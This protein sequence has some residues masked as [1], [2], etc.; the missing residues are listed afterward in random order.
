MTVRPRQAQPSASSF[1]SR[2]LIV[3]L[4][5]VSTS[6]LAQAQVC[7]NSREECLEAHGLPGCS[8]EQCCLAVCGLDSFCCEEWDANCA[9]L[10]DLTC[11]G[12]CGAQASGSCFAANGSGG[13][14]D[15]ACCGIVCGL[16][17]YCCDQ[18]WDGNCSLFAG[19]VCSVPGG[20]CGDPGTGDCAESNGT[21]SCEDAECCESVC[22]IDATC[23]D[24]VWDQLCVALADQACGGF[25]VVD[26][27]GTESMEAEA[28]DG[29]S[30]DP[31]DGGVAEEI[32][33][34]RVTVGTFRS[35][36]DVDVFRLDLTGRDV[37]ED[38]LVRMRLLF[39]ASAATLRF[40]GD[41]CRSTVEFEVSSTACIPVA[42]N[43]CLAADV[44]WVEIFPT[45]VI[46][47]CEDPAW[48]LDLETADTCGQIC[49]RPEDCLEPHA[50]PG[51]SDA[52]CCELVCEQDPECCEWAWDSTCAVQA[53]ALCG[54]P[55]PANDA[56]G[57]AIDIGP[58]IHPFRQ[59]LSSAEGLD[60]ECL[61]DPG[62]RGGD[63]W[64]RYQSTCDGLLKVG[65]C[66]LADFDTVVDVFAG[67]CKS[68]VPVVCLDDDIFC[69]FDT[70]SIFFDAQCGVD[71]LLRI[72][73][74]DGATG[75]G[76][77]EV[78]CF[79]PPCA[80]CEADLDGDGTVGGADFGLLLSAWGPCK[81]DC[82][83]D[84]DGDGT[85]DG[86]DLGLLL[87]AWGGC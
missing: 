40:R 69:T 24:A 64:F 86:P 76:S 23:C 10:A 9:Q 6:N 48:R 78:Q 62:L 50:H 11:A 85:V 8:D 58:G 59:L 51:C 43:Q 26:F 2:L 81:G 57:D 63:I 65:T 28:C 41:E 38:G 18:V 22:Q 70:A 67:D 29:D 30:N 20:D 66:S 39:T 36:T 45:G 1:L 15:A 74:V 12:L 19:F 4:A 25:C 73:G 79:I 27:D 32:A 84:L 17:P 56:C 3:L 46:G 71:Y 80:A 42:A 16:D 77:V 31:C 61:V 53:A 60:S 37:D 54:G 75:T 87:V 5:I 83:A 82:P 7:E 72:S 52:A 34:A 47:E 55:P 49:G 35:D 33:A 68:M 13:C 21:P 44:W 14:D